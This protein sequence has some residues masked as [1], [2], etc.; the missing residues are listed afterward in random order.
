[1]TSRDFGIYIL[2]YPGDFHLSCV[3]VRSIQHVNPDIP[4]MIIPGEGFDRHDHPFEV[5]IMPQ[6]GGF[7]AHMGYMDRCFW[8]FQGPFENFLYL[9]ADMICT[10]SLENLKRRITQQQGNFIYVHPSISDE[11]WLTLIHDPNHPERQRYARHV[12][13]EIGRGPLNEFDPDY[14][15]FAN[16]P[17]NAGLFASRRLVLTEADFASL[18]RT[19]RNYYRNVLKKDWTWKSSDLFFR[20]QGRLNYLVSKLSIPTFHLQPDL[21]CLAGASAIQVSFDRVA[22]D[23]CDFHLIHWMGSMSPSPSWFCVKPL[24]AVYA[25]LW[26]AVGQRTGRWMAPEYHRL[27]E[28]PGYSLWRHY[29]EQSYGA[30]PLGERLRWSWRHLKRVC[31]LAIRWLKLSIRDADSRA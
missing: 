11:D 9:D 22:R 24:F 31:K 19:E 25:F 23:S 28:S 18:N 27:P 13:R 2:T 7:W 16:Y 21:I 30:M 6:P 3:L 17:F 4:I 12:K 8:A 14:N 26:T 10:K 1:M 15:I 20:D 29:Y 5:P